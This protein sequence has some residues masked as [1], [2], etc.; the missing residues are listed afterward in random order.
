MEGTKR[1]ASPAASSRFWCTVRYSTRLTHHVSRRPICRTNHQATP[2]RGRLRWKNLDLVCDVLPDDGASDA[3][4]R[5][6]AI[7]TPQPWDVWPYD[8]AIH[9]MLFVHRVDGL[10]P[11]VYFL[12]RDSKKLT[13]I[14]ESMNPE[15]NWTRTPGTP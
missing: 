2:E 15:L 4:G 1:D 12:V 6:S 3:M 10:T 9:L 11:G 14:Q 13:F 7:G 5:T 8:P